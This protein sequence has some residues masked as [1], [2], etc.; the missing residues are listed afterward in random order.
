[1]LNLDEREISDDQRSVRHPQ[2]TNFRRNSTGHRVVY[3]KHCE[4][5]SISLS[6]EHSFLSM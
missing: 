6:L 4:I 3:G 1:M 5:L 2:S